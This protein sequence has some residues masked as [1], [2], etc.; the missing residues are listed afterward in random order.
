M[1][2]S[3]LYTQSVSALQ[4]LRY[5]GYEALSED[6]R[7][8]D[9]VTPAAFENALTTDMALGCSTNSALHLLAIAHEADI[10]LDLHMINDDQ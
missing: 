5:A 4:R 6:I 1:V 10:T 2:R 9:I 8:R 7:P 3:R